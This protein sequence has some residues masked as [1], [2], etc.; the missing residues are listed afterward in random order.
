MAVKPVLVYPNPMLKEISQAVDSIDD[1]IRA[2]VSD[3]ID[4]LEDSPGCVG[5]A[6][7]QIGVLKRIIL[8][9]ASRHPKQLPNNGRLVLINPRILQ[10][11]GEVLAREG[12]LS[13]PH[14]TANV[15]RAQNIEFEATDLNGQLVKLQTSDFEARVVLHEY[16]HLDGLLFLDRVASLKTDVFRRKNYAPKPPVAAAE[17]SP[18]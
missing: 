16:D 14:L 17:P 9:D 3:L 10:Q 12:C 18:G 8:V 7:P 6:A 15:K 4:T 11:D 1:E 5:I 13:L 2:A